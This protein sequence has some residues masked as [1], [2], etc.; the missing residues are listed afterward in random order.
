M[1]LLEQIEALLPQLRQNGELEKQRTDLQRQ[2]GDLQGEI[3]KLQAQHAGLMGQ[4]RSAQLK[5]D[6]LHENHNDVRARLSALLKPLA[7]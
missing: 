4:V 7:A 2:V 6:T 3:A 5:L 1:S